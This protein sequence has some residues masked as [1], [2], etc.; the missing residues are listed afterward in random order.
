MRL[1]LDCRPM[2]GGR[3]RRRCVRGETFGEQHRPLGHEPRHVSAVHVCGVHGERMQDEHVAG[4]AC[5]QHDF[6]G[7]TGGFDQGPCLDGVERPLTENGGHIAMGPDP[8]PRRRIVWAHLGQQRQNQYRVGPSGDRPRAVWLGCVQVDVPPSVVVWGDDGEADGNI[9]QRAPWP[10][11]SGAAD[12][13]QRGGQGPAACQLAEDTCAGEVARPH[14][15]LGPLIGAVL[16]QPDLSPQRMTRRVG[17][18]VGP[19]PSDLEEAVP[20]ERYDIGHGIRIAHGNW[21][22]PMIFALT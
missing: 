8:D 3:K 10:P 9:A 13:I 21:L 18:I 2:P 7:G 11:A 16:G 5:R 1:F 17:D 15:R 19:G 20:L 12:G 6:T 4:I 14:H 22:W